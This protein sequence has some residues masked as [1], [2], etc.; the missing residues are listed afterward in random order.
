MIVDPVGWSAGI[1]SFSKKRWFHTFEI[2]SRF[3]FAIVFMAAL[4]Y[5]DYMMLYAALSGLLAFTTVYLIVLGEKKHKQFAIWSARKFKKWFRVL[6][7]FSLAFGTFLV[8]T[9]M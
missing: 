3:L 1:V 4:T 7:F 5:S 8:T 2:I 9:L 6:G